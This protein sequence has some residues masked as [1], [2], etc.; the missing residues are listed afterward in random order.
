VCVCVVSVCVVGDE[1][2]VPL[3]P[4]ALFLFF[5]AHLFFSVTTEWLVEVPRS[6]SLLFVYINVYE[7]VSFR[8]DGVQISVADGE[9]TM[10]GDCEESLKS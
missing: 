6:N 7:Y 8:F 1:I 3:L 9:M 2:A 10:P 5:P 4:V